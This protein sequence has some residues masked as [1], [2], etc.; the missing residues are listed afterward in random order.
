MKSA[1]T[2]TFFVIC[3]TANCTEAF[4][5]EESALAEAEAR[6]KRDLE[7]EAESQV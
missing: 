7:L 3:L 4:K 1:I 5:V 2:C 6:W